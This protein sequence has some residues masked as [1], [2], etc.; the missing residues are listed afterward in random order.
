M[1]DITKVYSENHDQA[2]ILLPYIPETGD[3]TYYQYVYGV[4]DCDG[5]V[6]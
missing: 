6:A 1:Y 3:L 2:L 4:I 5:P